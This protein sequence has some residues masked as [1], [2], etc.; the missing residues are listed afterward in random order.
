[1]RSA[2]QLSALVVLL[3]LAAPAAYGQSEDEQILQSDPAAAEPSAEA[4]PEEPKQHPKD[5]DIDDED[6]DE[7]VFY[8]G[9]GIDRVST[10][11]DNLG[12]ATN[13]QAVLGFRIPTVRWI[14]LEVDLGQTLIPGDYRD[15]R[16]AQPAGPSCSPVPT[17]GC[18][19]AAVPAEKG[20]FDPEGDEFA[21]QALGISL[22][23][24]STGRFY[25]MGRYGYRYLATSNEALNEN[26]SGNG[27]GA[28]VGYR[29]GRGLS[30]VEL[31]YKELADNVESIGLTFYVRSSRR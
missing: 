13:L 16:P 4:P 5:Q 24:K 14:G 2:T 31:A 15:P 23:L 1:M 26:R 29:W 28:G 9:M 8:S 11:F 3:A 27:F 21:M 19:T 10:D 22:A 17:P 20:A 7:Q 6:L 25:V 18:G 12:E 30:G